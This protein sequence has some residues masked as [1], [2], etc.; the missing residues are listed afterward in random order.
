MRII[1]GEFKGLRFDIVKGYKGRPTTNFGREGLFNVLQN[2][3]DWPETRVL[4]LFSGTGSL[5]L[6]CSSR[7]AKSVVSVEKDRRASRHLS[8]L[9]ESMKIEDA[10]CVSSDVF[11]Y[12]D[13]QRHQFDLIIADPPFDEMWGARIHEKVFAKDILAEGG[14]LIIE[15]EPREVLSQLAHWDRTKNYG[16][17]HFSF[18]RK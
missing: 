4:D 8:K 17:V 5:S 15:H 7:G 1:G 18:F 16:K 3:I 11:F 6:E 9:I 13:K 2:S 10:Y 14:L 12:L